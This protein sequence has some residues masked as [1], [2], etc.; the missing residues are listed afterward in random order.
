MLKA[1]LCVGVAAIAVLGLPGIARA[2][3]DAAT[4]KAKAL[5]S[6]SEDVGN[7][8]S[9][10]EWLGPNGEIAGTQEGM[11]D[12]TVLI[13]DAVFMNTNTMSDPPAVSKALTFFNPVQDKIFF[14]SVG[15]DGDHWVLSKEVGSEI[16]TSDPHALADGRTLMIRF[17]TVEKTAD[18]RK[19]LMQRS[20]D[21]GATWENGF[22]QYMTRTGAAAEDEEAHPI[23]FAEVQ[24]PQAAPRD[25]HIFDPYIGTFR[26]EKQISD[27]GKE[28]FY[29]VSYNWYDAGHTVVKFTIKLVVPS[30]T[31]ER[32]NG[33]GYYGYDPFRKQLFVHGYFPGG[34]VGFG[35]VSEF[36]PSMGTRVTRAHSQSADGATT[37][38]RDTFWLIDKDSWG[39]ATFI[40]QDGGAWQKVHEGVY[41]RVQS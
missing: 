32:I 25:I 39:N 26:G 2:E 3:E 18:S 33:E 14:I 38:V 40:S 31:L 9:R 5:E 30:D 8:T 6:L 41:T 36:D 12:Y 13:P 21:N 23:D 29:D 11:E 4:Q 20:W 22:Y 35:A 27:E 1:C 28:F 10:W 24:I 37:E 17:T 34:V 7:W 15:Q 19:I 16:L